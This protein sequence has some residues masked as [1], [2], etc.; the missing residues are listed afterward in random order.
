VKAE[1]L[2][3]IENAAHEPHIVDTANFLNACG[4][5]ISGA[6]TDVIKIRGVKRLHG[7][8][9]TIIPDMIEAGTYMCLAGAVPGSRLRITNVIPKH[10]DSMSAKLVE[11]GLKIVEEDE[12]VVVSRSGDLNKI[13]VHT[14]PYPGFPTDMNP[15]ICVLLA[16]AKG[17][18]TLTEGVWDSRF[19]YVEELKRMGANI[20][21]DGRL[22]VVEGI[23]A[24]SPAPVRAVDLRAGAAMVIAALSAPGRTEVHEA[25]HIYRGYEKIVEKLRAVGADITAVT[26]PDSVLYKVSN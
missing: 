3:V 24:L 4:A 18:S 6:G 12:A 11:M 2:T 7:V 16:L 9:Y 26:I 19:R 15:Q 21:V 10:L 17:T 5:D 14:L 20:K 13:H 1:G 25:Y 23:K 8:T 22:A